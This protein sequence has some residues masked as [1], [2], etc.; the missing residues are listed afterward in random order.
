MHL[1]ETA[2]KFASPDLSTYQAHTHNAGVVCDKWNLENFPFIFTFCNRSWNE[3]ENIF[4]LKS[5]LME[6][7]YKILPFSL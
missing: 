6:S 2:V 4:K 1:P 5:I 7:Y 3:D